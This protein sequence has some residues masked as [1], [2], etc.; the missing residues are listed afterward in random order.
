M[1]LGGVLQG[2]VCPHSTVL[3]VRVWEVS[4][5]GW[6]TWKC[7]VVRTRVQRGCLGAVDGSWRSSRIGSPP[8]ARAN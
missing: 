4:E 3:M 2:P 8:G 1:A 6:W 7:I 5:C